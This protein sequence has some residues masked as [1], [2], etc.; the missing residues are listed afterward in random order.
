MWYC[1]RGLA[2]TL[3]KIIFYSKMQQWE[4]N[5][6]EKEILPHIYSTC[7]GYRLITSPFEYIIGFNTVAESKLI[8]FF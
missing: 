3:F 5:Q 4:N 8:N 7:A 6:H 2:K 1:M